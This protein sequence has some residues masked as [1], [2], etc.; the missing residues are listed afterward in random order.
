MDRQ[1]VRVPF[2]GLYNTWFDEEVN[3]YIEDYAEHGEEWK[4]LDSDL[5]AGLMY[6]HYDHNTYLQGLAALYC[7]VFNDWFKEQTGIDLH[8]EFCYTTS[9]K[10]YNF[11]TDHIIAKASESALMDAMAYDLPHLDL[12]IEHHL[13]SRSGFMSFYTDF[14]RGWKEKP[15]SAWDM[16]ECS[17]L[18]FNVTDHVQ[19]FD[20]LMFEECHEKLYSVIEAAFDWPAIESSIEEHKEGAKS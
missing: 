19:D 11:E 12:T 13:A 9:P 3:R 5:V 20:Y 8:L 6:N 16:H 18:L 2:Q 17:M 7:D 14:V 1:F 4:G 10:Y 15:L